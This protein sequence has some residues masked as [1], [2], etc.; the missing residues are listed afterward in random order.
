MTSFD[1]NVGAAAGGIQGCCAVILHTQ[2]STADCFGCNEQGKKGKFLSPL[3]SFPRGSI[4][5]SRTSPPLSWGFAAFS[6]GM[7]WTFLPCF[8]V[9]VNYLWRSG[10]A[11]PDRRAL[12][13]PFLR[14]GNISFWCL[15]PF[16]KPITSPPS[17]SATPG[18]SNEQFLWK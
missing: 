9:P 2:T 15:S 7:S 11:S 18:Q 3:V 14:P 16:H 8:T 4:Q 13:H 17:G 12:C 10:W 1:F 5:I 6:H